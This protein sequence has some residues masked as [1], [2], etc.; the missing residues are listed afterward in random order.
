MAAFDYSEWQAIRDRVLEQRMRRIFE[1]VPGLGSAYSPVRTT[2]EEQRKLY[3]GYLPYWEAEM[4][5]THL[6]L[7]FPNYMSESMIRPKGFSCF[8]ARFCHYAPTT[9]HE[10]EFFEF[11]FVVGGECMHFVDEDYCYLREGDVLLIP[12]GTK[13]QPVMSDGSYNLYSVGVSNARLPRIL[14]HLWQSEHPLMQYM[15][16]KHSSVSVKSCCLIRLEAGIQR[17]ILLPLVEDHYDLRDPF[18][19]QSVEM[20][21]ER[22]LMELMR[23]AHMVEIVEEDPWTLQNGNEILYY[24]QNHF[25]SVSRRELA[26]H[27]SYSERQIT[28]LLYKLTGKSLTEYISEVRMSYVTDMLTTTR[29]PIC[30][31]VEASGYQNNNYF[32]RLFRERFH[33][34]PAEYRT[35]YWLLGESA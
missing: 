20:L 32:Y 24:I 34:T 26:E 31:I 15:C 1:R 11:Q 10:H 19:I 27:F 28:R 16:E 25:K 14:S 8:N 30:E 3:E 18:A 6:D 23:K 29:A 5:N 12:P 2:R 21:L 13:H 33:M 7:G 9:M 22:I 35:R 4:G 17:Q